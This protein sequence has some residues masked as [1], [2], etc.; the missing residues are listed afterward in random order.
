LERRFIILLT[1]FLSIGQPGDIHFGGESTG[2]TGAPGQLPLSS[3][4]VA[5]MCDEAS[6]AL[7]EGYEQA[8]ARVG[9]SQN[10]HIDETGWKTVG[11]RRWLWVAFSAVG[12]VFHLSVS[13]GGAVL[14]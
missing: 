9:S 2:Y 10:C 6:A 3:G 12:V 4:S 11:K 13:R 7:E 8:K 5:A 1:D 14:Q